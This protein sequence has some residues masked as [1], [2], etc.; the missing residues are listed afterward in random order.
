MSI[1]EAEDIQYIGFGR[2]NQTSR[3]PNKQPSNRSE[4]DMD[5]LLKVVNCLAQKFGIREL[6]QILKHWL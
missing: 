3:I 2:H 6:I 1:E 5:E 4:E